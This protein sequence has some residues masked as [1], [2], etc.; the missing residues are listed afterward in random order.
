MFNPFTL[1]KR[2]TALEG[3]VATLMATE[4][5]LATSVT[6][7]ET[8]QAAQEAK[9]QAAV[10]EIAK[11]AAEIA[12]GGVIPQTIIDRLNAIGSKL[13]ADATTLDNATTAG[14]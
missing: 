9:I 4:A 12:A 14:G 3:K 1:N 11:L 5:E 2:V 6:D 8:K 13:D 7:L 10:D